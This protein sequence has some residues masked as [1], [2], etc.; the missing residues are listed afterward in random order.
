MKYVMICTKPS[1]NQIALEYIKGRIWTLGT[2]HVNTIVVT[3][4]TTCKYYFG[5]MLST[6]IFNSVC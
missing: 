5:C 6:K 4:T 1:L 2:L 3:P